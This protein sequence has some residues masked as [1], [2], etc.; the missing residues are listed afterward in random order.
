LLAI[1]IDA[2]G[3][4]IGQ[5]LATGVVFYLGID[6]ERRSLED[7]GK[8]LNLRLF[9]W[10]TDGEIYR[11][12]WRL[13]GERPV[14]PIFPEPEYKFEQGGKMLVETFAGEVVRAFDPQSDREIRY[15]WSVSPLILSDAVLAINGLA[16]WQPHFDKLLA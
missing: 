1:P 4:A 11:K 3:F 15:R 10:T 2:E 12:N 7:I 5:V 16:P 8:V 9:A 13:I 14:P 6:P